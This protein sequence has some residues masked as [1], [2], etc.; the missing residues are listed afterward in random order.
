MP[1]NGL[2]DKTVVVAGPFGTLT[3][4]LTA[5]LAEYGSNVCLVTNNFNAADR[6]CQNLSDMR[7]VSER[8]GRTAAV[9]L[10][11]GTDQDMRGIFSRGAELFGGIDIYIDA[12]LFGLEIPFYSKKQDYNVD[13][14]F[15]RAFARLKSATQAAV[16]YM[17]TR[18]RGR[19]LYLCHALDMLAAQKKQSSVFENFNK[20][21]Q[22]IAA[23]L[24][25]QS[26]TVNTLAIGVN[27]EYL[28][29]R[30]S[31]VTI[32]TALKELMKDI[33]QAKIIDYN[34][35]ANWTSYIVSPASSGLSGQTIYLNHGL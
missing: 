18:S 21:V 17:K 6:V 2:N 28:L 16:A 24:V 22:N 11:D 25:N 15:N 31:Q 20:Y 35:I 1:M 23:E 5:R 27:E 10:K 7:E 26:T 32:Q 19:V 3:Q 12:N 9:E 33:P 29:N 13:E 30:F 14:N 4:T 8:F 34:E